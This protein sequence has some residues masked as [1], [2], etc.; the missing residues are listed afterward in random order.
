MRLKRLPMLTNEELDVLYGA[1]DD[2]CRH[3]PRVS[4][5]H[6]SLLNSLRTLVG[7]TKANGG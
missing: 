3:Q 1:L 2:A 5:R 7:E 6:W 4:T